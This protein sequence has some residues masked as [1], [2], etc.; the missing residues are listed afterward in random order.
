MLGCENRQIFCPKSTLHSQNSLM[1]ALLTS[2]SLTTYHQHYL[3]FTHSPTL[4]LFKYSSLWAPITTH[5]V[6]HVSPTY[7]SHTHHLSLT[8]SP[9]SVPLTSHTLTTYRSHT[10]YHSWTHP[11]QS[12]LLHT[13]SPTLTIYHSHTHPCRHHL[14]LT[15][16]PPITHTLTHVSPTYLSHAHHLPLTHNLPLMHS[17]ISVPVTT[18]TITHSH[19]LSLTH[20]SMSAPLTSHIL[21]TYHSHTHL[22]QPHLQFTQLP[23]PAPFITHTLTYVSPTYNSHNYPCQ[24]HLSLIHSFVEKDVLCFVEYVLVFR[25]NLVP[26]LPW[27]TWAEGRGS[28]LSGISAYR[29]RRAVTGNNTHSGIF[30]FKT[31]NQLHH[32]LS[33]AVIGR[34]LIGFQTIISCGEKV[35]DKV[36]LVQAFL[37]ALRCPPVST[38]PP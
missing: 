13:Q 6:I 3:T 9:M 31:E 17:S 38:F 37:G 4:A 10:I 16:S 1:S 36:A 18:H 11:Y 32:A 28:F 22:C 12:Q 25:R 14:P 7:L 8:H 23:M 20:T 29:G 30:Y 33:Q 15:Y 35:L 24:P 34:P 27:N 5:T 2:H 26:L 21:T 19:H